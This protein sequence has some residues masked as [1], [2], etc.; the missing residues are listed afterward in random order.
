MPSRRSPSLGGGSRIPIRGFTKLLRQLDP[1]TQAKLTDA[2]ADAED[3]IDFHQR[4]TPERQTR[5]RRTGRIEVLTLEVEN[6]LLGSFLSWNRS[7]D[8]RVQFY[9][10]QIANDSA[11]ANPDPFQVLETFIAF[12]NIRTTQFA[13]VRAVTANGDVGLFSNTVR[14]RPR[15]SAPNVFSVD[16]YGRYGP[17]SLPEV[18]KSLDYSGG[19][20]G[21]LTEFYSVLSHDF[22][23]DRLVGGVSV[24]GYISSRMRGFVDGGSTVWDKMRFRVNGLTRSRGYWPMSVI[25]YTEDDFHDNERDAS[26]NLMTFYGL[27]GYTASFGPYAIDLPN[28]VEGVGPS[29]ASSVTTLDTGAEVFYWS[30]V[31]NA[32]L[33]SRYDQA[34]LSSLDDDDPHHE[35]STR[36]ITGPGIP[37]EYLVF[38]DFRFGV[39]PDAAIT[40]IEARIKRRQISVFQNPIPLDS[41]P[42]AVNRPFTTITGIDDGDILVDSETGGRYVQAGDQDTDS[43]KTD[44]SP[45]TLNMP[46]NDQFTLIF[47]VINDLALVQGG[48]GNREEI[49]EIS[50]NQSNLRFRRETE[51]TT[52]SD[53]LTVI[54]DAEGNPGIDIAQFE[55]VFNTSNTFICIGARYINGD[56]DI[57]I[58]GSPRAPVSGNLS[59]TGTFNAER[60]QLWNSLLAGGN[61]FQGGMAHV[62]LFSGFFNDQT[63]LDIG[64]ERR[65]G[66][67]DYRLDTYTNG[68]ADTLEHY[69]LY[70]PGQADMRDHTVVLFGEN[71]PRTD[72]ENKAVNDES[73][74]RLADFFYTDER[75]FGILPLGVSGGVPHDNHTAIGYQ[76][77]GGE[78]DLWS[79][80]FTP[81]EVNDFYFGF[82]IR[83]Q[84]LSTDF[85]GSGYIDHGELIV[86]TEPVLDRQVNV[87][88]EVAAASHFYLTRRVFGGMLNFIELGERLA[89]LPDC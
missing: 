78:T 58:D 88:V 46:S 7:N 49:L 34:Q 16:F 73:W 77:Y 52:G 67:V 63:M 79:G 5:R 15:I 12:E 47:W 74:P 68:N 35:A 57:F 22:Y 60:I 6:N 25:R 20:D 42:N 40:G 55:D 87:N 72:L 62:A 43:L 26:G 17:D 31:N 27:G 45:A 66:A 48:G 36:G 75:Q 4:N 30:D 84:N 61:A 14:I 51:G 33:P 28:T 2:F 81:S 10:V 18:T 64:Q 19:L 50:G 11:F 32:Q 76:R 83:A 44:A 21:N 37:T 1:A 54:L 71:G 13:R 29:D 59:V 8:P 89:D 24:W 70:I 69:W 39:P 3:L 65:L 38:R 86:Y 53:R 41:G 23:A 56:M 82:G 85:S 9:E 80:S